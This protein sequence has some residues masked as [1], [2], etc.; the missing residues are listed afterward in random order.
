MENRN[1]NPPMFDEIDAAFNVRGKKVIFAW[2]GIIYNPQNVPLTPSLIAHERIH[3][4][5]QGDDIEGWWHKYIDDPEFR[6]AEEIEAHIAEYA[7]VAAYGNRRDRR[8][9][10]QGMSKRLASPMY[11][12]LINQAQA[13]RIILGD[14]PE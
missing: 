14:H 6:L 11:G 2:G 7:H 5:R 1:A 8:H 12:K 10:I 13:K 4:L 9:A 3:G